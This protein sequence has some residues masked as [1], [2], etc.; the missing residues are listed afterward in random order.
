MK[1]GRLV[2]GLCLALSAVIIAQHALA[3][4][5]IE[6]MARARLGDDV[7]ISFIQNLGPLVA[8]L[9]LALSAVAVARETMTNKSIENTAHARLGDDVIV[10]STQNQA[11]QYDVRPVTLIDFRSER[12]AKLLDK[13]SIDAS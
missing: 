11:G 3:N 6:K 9:C 1:I 2:V 8:G 12:V 5:S 4:E 13:G 7:I 10:S